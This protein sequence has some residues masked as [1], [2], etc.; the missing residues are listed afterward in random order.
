M[1]DTT[2]TTFGFTK[3]EVGASQNTWGTKLNSNFDEVDDCLDGTTAIKPNL[4][5][6]QWE[7]GGVA[8]TST[9]AELNLL[10]GV[11]ATTTEINK[12]DGLTATTAELN[13]LDGVT[14]TTA[15]LNILDGVTATASEINKLDG[16][17]GTVT[18]LNY[19]KDLRATG[20]TS[21]EFDYLDGVT[22]NIQTQLN[23]KAPL[24][25]PALTGTPTA[26][27]AGSGSNSTQIATT[28]FVQAA[29]TAALQAVYPVGS[30]YINASSTTNPATL[31]GFGTWVDFGAGR[32]LVGQNAGDAS[33][34]TLQETGGSKT[35]TPSGSVTVSGHA[36]TEAEMPKH[37]H[38]MRGPN[39]ISAPQNN[40]GTGSFGNYGGGTPDD[41]A[42]QYGTYSAG[43]GA[44]SG[45][46]STGTGNGNAH[47]H[48][49][50]FSGS[51]TS[52]VQPYIVVKMWR[53]TA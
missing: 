50:S 38:Q 52:V 28:A 16:F 51:S 21:T 8:V 37:Y 27:T 32:V 45:G 30:I 13:L 40:Q 44:S 14:A 20:V 12:L 18:D 4:T 35:V 49:A 7:V 34:D 24:V 22:S 46:T 43:G 53:R 41:A 1:A 36:L 26:P 17:T 42:Q 25:S 29:A 3:P 6:G 9:A 2:T 10:D 48:S 33:F 15:E 11:T 5:T 23:T 39:S 19:A 47:T 31:L